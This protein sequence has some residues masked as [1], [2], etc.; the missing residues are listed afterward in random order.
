ME[1]TEVNR[2]GDMLDYDCSELFW[3]PGNCF[4]EIIIFEM[5]VQLANLLRMI[6]KRTCILFSC[7]VNYELRN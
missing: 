1:E 4:I 5:Y 6:P 7:D 3:I 2:T